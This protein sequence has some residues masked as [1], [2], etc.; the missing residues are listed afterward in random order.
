MP[1]SN[2]IRKDLAGRIYLK[3]RDDKEH[4][5]STQ[6]LREDLFQ[7]KTKSTKT[8]S[9]LFKLA[10]VRRLDDITVEQANEQLRDIQKR[11]SDI[12]LMQGNPVPY[13]YVEPISE[14][15]VSQV[16][17]VFIDEDL[18]G[19]NTPVYIF[20]SPSSFVNVYVTANGIGKDDWSVHFAYIVNTENTP[21]KV[22]RNIWRLV[23][24]D[25]SLNIA[26]T[27][28]NNTQALYFLDSPTLPDCFTYN[29]NP[30]NLNYLGGGCFTAMAVEEKERIPIEGIARLASGRYKPIGREFTGNGIRLAK[31]IVAYSFVPSYSFTWCR[32]K[33]EL[34]S[35]SK[36]ASTNF[37][38]KD[39]VV[40][41]TKE[42][43]YSLNITERPDL[44]DFFGTTTVNKIEYSSGNSIH[45]GTTNSRVNSTYQSPDYGTDS[46][47]TSLMSYSQTTNVIRPRKIEL[48]NEL[49]LANRCLNIYKSTIP[50][51]A[52]SNNMSIYIRLNLG[53]A[54]GSINHGFEQKTTVGKRSYGYE[55]NY[56]LWWTYGKVLNFYPFGDTKR[57]STTKNP[58]TNFAPVPAGSM[59]DFGELIAVPD[60]PNAVMTTWDSP[61]NPPSGYFNYFF[62]TLQFKIEYLNPPIFGHDCIYYYEINPSVRIPGYDSDNIYVDNIEERNSVNTLKLYYTQILGGLSGGAVQSINI[63]NVYNG[64]NEAVT[65]LM[66]EPTPQQKAMLL[67]IPEVF[68]YLFWDDVDVSYE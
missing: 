10:T 24:I 56:K 49:A 58:L 62:G 39:G 34:N 28:I 50:I 22:K 65:L 40:Y 12:A 43:D 45:V 3:G 18:R 14:D 30:I 47:R 7:I 41:C 55:H 52:A 31:C 15:G 17:G 61:P 21:E 6:I 27:V 51:L 67:D 29:F 54:S 53:E 9:S 37:T 59:F 33:L 1:Q 32:G 4:L 20:S 5:L 26:G 57:Y 46:L 64:I 68:P 16:Y 25:N 44:S 38:N 48:E 63:G 42:F 23:S 11:L 36:K 13:P 2:F 60:I 8:K 19:R 35:S 66:R